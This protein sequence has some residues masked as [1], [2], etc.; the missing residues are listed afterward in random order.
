ME[1][2]HVQALVLGFVPALQIDGKG[3]SG[4]EGG[5]FLL[6]VL[7]VPVLRPG[8]FSKLELSPVCFAKLS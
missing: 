2:V 5:R 3:F 8:L 1:L 4:K 6:A 7:Q